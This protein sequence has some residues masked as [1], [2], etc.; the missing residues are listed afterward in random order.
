MWIKEAEERWI[1]VCQVGFCIATNP[2]THPPTFHASN[3]INGVEEEKSK[4]TFQIDDL[5]LVNE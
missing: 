3:M 1:I 5:L 4:Q 2:P